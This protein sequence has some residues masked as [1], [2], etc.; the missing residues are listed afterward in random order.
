MYIKK[1]KLGVEVNYDS[2][3]AFKQETSNHLGNCGGASWPRRK[4]KIMR[5][6]KK[7]IQSEV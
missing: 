5:L 3:G 6:R 1:E 4:L 7:K 2:Q